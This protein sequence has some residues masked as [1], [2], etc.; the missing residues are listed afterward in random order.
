MVS[1]V[2]GDIARDTCWYLGRLG[3]LLETGAGFQW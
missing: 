3:S 2:V 1:R